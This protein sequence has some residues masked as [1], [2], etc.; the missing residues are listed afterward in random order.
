MY[1]I[2]DNVPCKSKPEA[3]YAYGGIYLGVSGNR[4]LC[5]FNDMLQ[6]SLTSQTMS[7]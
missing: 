5:Y 7:N 3:L 4:S 1:K 2:N 6:I